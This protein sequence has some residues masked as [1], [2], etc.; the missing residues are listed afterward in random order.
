MNFKDF[1]FLSNFENIAHGLR[2]EHNLQDIKFDEIYPEAIRRLSPRHFTPVHIAI[3]AANLLVNKPSMNILDIGSGVGKFCFVAS[4]HSDANYTGIEQRKKFYDLATSLAIEK[5]SPS[6]KF[7]QGD[8]VDL[9]FKNYDGFYFYNSF[10]EYINKTCIIDR[11]IDKSVASH[12]YYHQRLREKLEGARIGARLVT[13]YTFPGEI[14]DSYSIKN[15]TEG[16]LL[17]LWVKEQ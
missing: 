14:P 8:F 17:K 1:D 16:G 9:D 5:K 6:V 10:E 13:Y 4:E 12:K 2:N 7:I 11:T 15:S 3:K